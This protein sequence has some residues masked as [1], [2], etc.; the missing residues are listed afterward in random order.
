M[1][2]GRLIRFIALIL[3]LI[4]LMP[5]CALAEDEAAEPEAVAEGS[6][7]ENS[8]RDEFID[9]IIAL[10]EQKYT[11]ANGRAQR[12]QYAGDI[13]IC[14]NFVTY[15]FTSNADKYRM[16]EYPD[17]PLKIPANKKAT[18]KPKYG[19]GVMW[20]DV[21]ASDGNPFYAAAQFL[22]DPTLSKKENRENA[23]EFLTQVK[24]GDFGQM[25]VSYYYGSGPHSLIFIA[26]YDEE[27]DTV[28]WTDSN[29]PGERRNGIRYGYVQYD[30]TKEIEFFIDAFC[31]PQRGA[32]LY[33]L[34]DDIIKAED[35]E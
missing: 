29:M 10:A 6:D 23:R 3:S 4:M 2:Y 35:A 18:T 9:D 19:S 33:R 11:D 27:N 28:T 25:N 16:Q 32:T 26:D 21:P 5:L 12:A 15:L 24:R 17:V 20:Q 34:R 13:Y 1:K 22:Y 30:I 8:A 14:R 7:G 31:R